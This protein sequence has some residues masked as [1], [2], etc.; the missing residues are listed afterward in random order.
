MSKDIF[1]NIIGY[2]D[3]KEKLRI[4]IDVIEH[5][6]KCEKL[7]VKMPHGLFLYGDPG[8]GKTTIAND[9][10]NYSKRKSVVIRKTKSDGDFIKHLNKMF[11]KAIELQPSIILLDD[12]DKFA[13]DDSSENNEEYVTIQSLI[14]SI[15]EKDIFVIATANNKTEI[16]KSLLRSGRFDNIFRVDVPSK[17]DTYKI[18]KYYLESKNIDDDVNFRNISSILVDASCADLEKVCNQAGIYA[19]YKNKEKIGMEDLIN[20]SVEY[21]YGSYLSSVNKESKYSLNIA[22]HE[23]GHALV[24]EILEPKSIAFISITKTDS[25]FKGLTIFDVNEDY[26]YDIKFMINRIKSLLAGKAATEVVFN[27]CDVGTTSDLNRAFD[28]ADRLVSNYCIH[29]FDSW[30]QYEPITSE[31]VKENICDKK[32]NI[33]K[34]YYEE[35]KKLIIDNRDKLDAL[36]KKLND[37]KI[38]FQ[39]DI[40]AILND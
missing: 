8:T 3:L 38:L 12:L 25:D 24:G 20:A 35:V 31:K 10:I 13:E 18:C 19:S 34:S 37:K 22:Y 4:I 16:P 32:I 6:N 29:G 26:F 28:I 9:I 33:I 11:D 5:P 17:E 36:A 7:G 27:T 39:D 23:A 15:K 30:I 2:D 14:D 1:N 40:D 21:V